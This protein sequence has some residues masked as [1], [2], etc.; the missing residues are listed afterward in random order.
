MRK[1]ERML[2]KAGILQ[3]SGAVAAGAGDALLRSVVT[4]A[5]Q[6]A[7]GFAAG[8][9][10]VFGTLAPFGIAACAT[11]EKKHG[12]F[13]LLGAV[14]A[15][16][17]PGGPELPV[18]YLAAMAAALLFR[19][20][21]AGLQAPR[22]VCAPACAGAAA[23][24][25]GV[26]VV[27]AQGAQAHDAAL[28]LAETLLCACAA[29]FFEQAAPFFRRPARVWALSA[30]EQVCVLFC[31]CVL[32]LALEPLAV[33]GV[34]LGRIAAVLAVL[35]AARAGGTSAGCVVGAVLGLGLGLNGHE[36]AVLLAG[37]AVA[38]LAAGFFAPLG[39]F[40]SALAFVLANAAAGFSIGGG[41]DLVPGLVEVTVAA[42]VFLLL[43]QGVLCRV[44]A[45]FAVSGERKAA[46]QSARARL[47]EASQALRDVADTI[48][49][50]GE[51]LQT[52]QGEPPAERLLEDAAEGAC[53]LCGL[54]NYCWSTAYNNTI[55]ALQRLL[56]ALQA[57]GEA[58]RTD[59]PA[60]FAGRC[61]RLNDLLASVNR[62]YAEYTAQ[63]AA[64]R[65]IGELRGML[66]EQ[67]NIIASFLAELGETAAADAKVELGAQPVRAAF[68]A[69]GLQTAFAVCQVDGGGRL[70]VEARLAAAPAVPINRAE[71]A[72]ELSSACGRQMEGPFVQ[73]GGGAA[74]LR[75]EQKA[76]FRLECGQFSI[77]KEGERLCGDA[78]ASFTENGRAVLVLSDG[79]GAGGSAAV[80]A[81]LAVE[82]IT[83]LLQAGFGFSA[84]LRAVNSAL[85]LKSGEESFA[86]LDIASVDLYTG[87]AEFFK[88]G[89]PPSYLRRHGHA[90]RIIHRSMPVGILQSA[91]FAHTSL[92]LGRDD[93]LVLVSDGACAVD[94]TWLLQELLRFPGGQMDDFS[95][96]LA[97]EAKRH[98]NDGHDDDI[99]V[100][101]AHLF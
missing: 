83:R 84:A 71:L 16:L 97:D 6:F 96:H 2:K 56:P 23:G 73:S 89:A 9:A 37:Y 36:T 42:A 67:W 72:Q 10:L 53:R 26:A 101:A 4:A 47:R 24:V 20:L 49:R 31:L 5:V 44:S 58:K 68:A 80:D 66:S 48:S 43:P 95:R 8:R 77:T 94:D 50:V 99:T 19:L 63:S 12:L 30:R 86:T 32:L 1:V 18:R 98:R 28:C 60:H 29:Y 88:A 93:L 38:G 51:R 52:L 55:D 92:R 79:M 81:N 14:C 34:S 82:L 100:L 11:V 21:C 91:G 54:K 64:K 75:F 7:V 17:L 76:A 41:T 69:C 90:E 85:M 40:G 61:C 59:V 62:R 25:T 27:L 39:R 35:L 87:V 70:S 13:L 78:A 74:V 57:N 15:A 3:A 45:L 65:R 33:S 46:P 22:S